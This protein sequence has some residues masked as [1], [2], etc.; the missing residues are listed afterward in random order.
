MCFFKDKFHAGDAWQISSDSHFSDES[1]AEH[2]ACASS[3]LY[4][5]TKEYADMQ[6]QVHQY[7]SSVRKHETYLAETLETLK[8]KLGSQKEYSDFLQKEV[9]RLE[10]MIKEKESE[11][12]SMWRNMSLL[13]E[14]CSCTLGEI[15]IRNAQTVGRSFAPEVPVSEKS[16]R[17]ITLPS[18]VNA[19]E[20]ADGHTI[21]FTDESIRT[22]ADSLVSAVQSSATISETVEG[23]QRELKSTILDLQ[24]E[25][26][27][28]DIELKRI[29]E[30]LVSQ[31]RDAE[32]AAKR[33]LTNLESARLQVSY[34]ENKVAE[35]ENDK[36][37]LESRCSQ[38]KDCEGSL[39]ELQDRAKLLNDSLAAKDQGDFKQIS[40]FI[41]F[42]SYTCFFPNDMISDLYL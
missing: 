38:L 28:K 22:M 29:S 10:S 16:R 4:E 32:A 40:Y 39:K 15:E 25:L 31:I 18:Y 14:A 17:G 9:T 1:I 12:S 24:R 37:L 36:Q 34:L 35:L 26:Q 6:E 8:R 7:L 42:L 2:L 13:Y 23:N 33:S 41:L 3:A 11:I 5:C 27:E 19:K 21:L 30:E 20:D